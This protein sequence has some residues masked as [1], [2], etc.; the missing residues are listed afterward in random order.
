MG[1]KYVAGVDE[2]GRGALAGPVLAAAVILPR[3]PSRIPS[4]IRDSKKLTPKRRE[5]LF[6]TITASSLAIGIGMIDNR[7]IDDSSILLASLKA[8]KR[9]V[10]SLTPKADLVLV[11]GNQKILCNMAQKT[12][13]AGDSLSLSIGAAS[14]VAKVIRDK[15]MEDYHRMHPGYRFD[16]N[17]GYGTQAHMTSI[18]RIGHCEIHRLTYRGVIHR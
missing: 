8:M 1:F 12:I 16:I 17:K 13:K 5:E 6:K 15:I 4:G 10:E 2:V 3:E 11:D 7:E 9:A 14:I 18:K